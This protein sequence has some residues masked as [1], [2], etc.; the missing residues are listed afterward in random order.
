MSAEELL[1]DEDDDDR[2]GRPVELRRY[3]RSLSQRSLDFFSKLSG[4]Y[5]KRQWIGFSFIEN[6]A[7]SA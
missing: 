7:G 1:V 3:M 6:G 5:Q 4:N 2:T